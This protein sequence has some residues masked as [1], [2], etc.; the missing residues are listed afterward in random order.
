MNIDGIT[1]FIDDIYISKQINAR[2]TDTLS[3]IYLKNNDKGMNVDGITIP[4][5]DIYINNK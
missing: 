5:D 3:V 4:I 2:A 1:M